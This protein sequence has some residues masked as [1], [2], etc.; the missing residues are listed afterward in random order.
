MFAKEYE[1]RYSDIGKN[2]KIKITTVLDLLQDIS[3]LHSDFVGLTAEKF[4]SLS[5]ACLLSGWRLKF[6][7]PID[8]REKVVIKTGIMTVTQ[9][10]TYRKYEVYQKD[11]CVAIATANWFTVNTEKM[12]IER[13]SEGFFSVFESV[14]EEDNGLPCAKLRP[15]E[16]TELLYET[17]VLK[18]DMDTNNHM[19]NVKSVELALDFIPDDFEVSQLHVKYRKELKEDEALK[20][21]GINSENETQIEIKNEKDEVCVLVNVT[22]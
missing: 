22:K 1:L 16:N 10:E 6:L 11:E 19:N 5:L 7:K 20:I 12:R 17:K 4:K 18:R 21:C 3:I 8:T 9:F 2:G 14:S 13:V 15:C